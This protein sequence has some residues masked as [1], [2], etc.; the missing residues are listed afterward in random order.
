ME[1]TEP[2]TRNERGESVIGV[3][4]EVAHMPVEAI[5]YPECTRSALIEDPLVLIEKVHEAIRPV[6]LE[7]KVEVLCQHPRQQPRKLMAGYSKGADLRINSRQSAVLPC[8]P[9]P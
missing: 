9:M 2:L 3:P 7:V 4:H 5:L 8:P 6:L 1:T